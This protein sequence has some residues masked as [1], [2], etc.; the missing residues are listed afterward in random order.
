MA[1]QVAI[2]AVHASVQNWLQARARRLQNGKALV[3]R[4]E[5]EVARVRGEVFAKFDE[6][7]GPDTY[8]MYECTGDLAFNRMTRE[9]QEPREFDIDALRERLSHDEF[10][11]VTKTVVD[12]KALD[13]AL[14]R[15]QVDSRVVAECTTFGRRPLFTWSATGSRS[16]IKPRPGEIAVV[17]SAHLAS[18][19]Q[20]A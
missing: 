13:N 20:E 9:M 18:K 11:M 4:G 3:A 5:A 6:M 15:H 19:M 1:R 10:E 8:V 12:T 16:E 2:F 7:Y 17:S 14:A